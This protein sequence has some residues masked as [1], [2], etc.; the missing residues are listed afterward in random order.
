MQHQCVYCETYLMKKTFLLLALVGT[1][2]TA[3]AQNGFYL[4]Y[5]I[6]AGITNSNQ[7]LFL[8]TPDFRPLA[9]YTAQISAGYQYKRWRLEAGIQRST[10]GYQLKNLLFASQFPDTIGKGYMKWRYSHF[11]IP[12][13]IG[14]EIPLSSRFSLTPMVEAIAGYNQKETIISGGYEERKKTDTPDFGSIYNRF[15]FWT[16]ATLKAEYKITPR[17]TIFAGPEFQYMV[18]NL[19]KSKPNA[20]FQPSMHNYSLMFNIGL[21]MQIR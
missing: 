3:S 8:S 12:V 13:K 9:G 5:S 6:G 19:V 21:K 11:M 1:G 14:Y 2:L 4:N 15:S 20:L 10:T 16:G 7:K 18:S 17:Y